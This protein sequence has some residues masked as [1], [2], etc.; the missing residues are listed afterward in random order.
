[1]PDA[2]E[3]AAGPHERLRPSDD[4]TL[5]PAGTRL[6]GRALGIDVGG[7]SVKAAV[8]DLETGELVLPPGA[9]DPAERPTPRPATPEAV[10]EVV[11]GV[12]GGLVSAGLVVP[13]M[14]AGCGL[15][16]VIKE[17]RPMTAAN[18]D[19]GWI[20]FPAQAA[21]AERLGRPVLALNDADAAGLAEMTYGVGAG[22]GGT[23]MLL[24]IGTGIGSALF[25]DGVLVPNTELGHIELRGEDAE[26][27][28]SG[29]AR[30]R[31][32]LD[33]EAW[34]VDFNAYLA[35]IERYF[36]PD[37]IVLGG[38]VSRALDQ[39]SHLL[40]SRATIVPARLR[41]NAGIAGAALAGANVAALS[42]PAAG[43][44]S[45]QPVAG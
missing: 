2:N 9:D 8:V 11:H 37:L 23:V 22:R 10:I 1:M 31:R 4:P 16:V 41:Q 30:E 39:F 25:I 34:A 28:V 6:P 19:R 12:V 18:I 3:T 15:P 33:W 36:W 45:P 20:G 32:G 42:A 27:L 13:G 29:A 44:S 24:T 40:R 21:L 35:L 17:G 7:T 5:P 43:V 14:P 26:T 38:G